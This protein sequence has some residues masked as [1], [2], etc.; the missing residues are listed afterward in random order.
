MFDTVNLY[1]DNV[2]MAVGDPFTLTRY[3]SNITERQN[4]KTGYSVVGS[5]GEYTAAIFQNGISLKGS[6]A[7]YYL[8]SNLLT[9]SRADVER[10]FEKM[11]D[12]LHVDVMGAKV[13]RVDISTI[14]PT[15]RPPADYYS[16]LG[17]KP[18]FTRLIATKDTLYYRTKHKQL[19]FYD[20]AKEMMSNGGTIPAP[21]VGC[22]L[23]RYELRLSG[24]IKQQLKSADAITALSLYNPDLYYKLIQLWKYEFSTIRKLKQI[25]AMADNIKTPKEAADALFSRLLRDAGGQSVIDDFVA[26]LKAQNTFTVPDYYTRLKNILSKVQQTPSGQQAE[27]IVELEKAISEVATFAR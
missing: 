22:N 8:N 14:I 24:R 1:L 2:T 10:A 5:L 25:S 9:L 6:L 12:Q 17:S 4:A 11:S 26:D 23:M 7:K 3:L 20:K 19:A 21:M 16:G 27:L 18:H 13:T 15:S